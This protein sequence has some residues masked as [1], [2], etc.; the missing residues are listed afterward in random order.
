MRSTIMTAVLAAALCFGQPP[1]PATLPGSPLS[2]LTAMEFE[3]FR[4]GL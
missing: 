4:I 3:L 2:G 1:A